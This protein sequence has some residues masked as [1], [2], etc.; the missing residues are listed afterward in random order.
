MQ[1]INTL[2]AHSRQ[3]KTRIY[4]S[5]LYIIIGD[6][7][8][9]ALVQLPGQSYR[10]SYKIRLDCSGLYLVW[11]LQCQGWRLYNLSG[12]TAHTFDCLHGTY[13]HS[14]TLLFQLI[15]ITPCPPVA[16]HHEEPGS[17][18]LITFLLALEGRR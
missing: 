4:F 1:L 17:H 15:P 14:E 5:F 12:Q 6:H 7:L 8:R 2:K 16:H 18:S 3:T 10:V 13:D 9:K 11:S